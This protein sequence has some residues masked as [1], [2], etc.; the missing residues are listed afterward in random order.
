MRCKAYLPDFALAFEH[1]C[2]HTGGRGVLDELQKQLKLLPEAM[3]PSRAALCR[4]ART[5]PC[6]VSHQLTHLVHR[7]MNLSNPHPRRNSGLIWAALRCIPWR[8]LTRRGAQG[9]L[10]WSSLEVGA[11]LSASA[12]NAAWA[13]LSSQLC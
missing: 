13:T 8:L 4:C 9:A 10:S 1:F 3:A 12:C 6:C 2:I 11:G 5:A 7:F